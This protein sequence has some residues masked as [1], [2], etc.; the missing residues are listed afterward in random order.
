MHKTPCHIL[1]D[2]ITLDER[3]R[4]GRVVYFL[5]INHSKRLKKIQIRK[6][7]GVELT[8]GS[9]AV[10]AKVS[11][12]RL[13]RHARLVP[14]L[15]DLGHAEFGVE[16]EEETPVDDRQVVLIPVPQILQVLV[17]DGGERVH[18]DNGRR[19]D[20]LRTSGSDP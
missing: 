7:Y 10:V 16:A 9:F 2:L 6:V 12:L 1:Y 18:A 8:A 4:Y 19:P 5:N 11:L 20:G 17:V 3:R 13:P 14:H 15:V